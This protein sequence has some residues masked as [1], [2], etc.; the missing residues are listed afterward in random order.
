MEIKYVCTYL[1]SDDGFLGT[2]CTPENQRKGREKH[3]EA[4]KKNK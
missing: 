2:T 1:H 3:K 4:N